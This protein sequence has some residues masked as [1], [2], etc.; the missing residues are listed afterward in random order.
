MHTKWRQTLFT[1]SDRNIKKNPTKPTLLEVHL[2]SNTRNDLSFWGLVNNY[3]CFTFV[4]NKVQ[5]RR[6]IFITGHQMASFLRASQIIYSFLLW[7]P[8][9][10]N[11]L[12]S[13]LIF[14]PVATCT[15]MASQHD[16]FCI[17]LQVI[18]FHQ[19]HLVLKAWMPHILLIN[20]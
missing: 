15:Q 12:G 16:S 19:H 7:T 3:H 8:N 11:I 6:P 18:F 13:V 5:D 20:I 4:A 10:Y 9:R 2:D 14:V 17:T 1:V